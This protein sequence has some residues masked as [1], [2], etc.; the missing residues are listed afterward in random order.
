MGDSFSPMVF[1]TSVELAG[2]VYAKK[3]DG[4]PVEAQVSYSP[5]C[6]QSEFEFS[7]GYDYASE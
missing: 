7:F 2:V 1:A 4:E 3:A 5:E 6:L